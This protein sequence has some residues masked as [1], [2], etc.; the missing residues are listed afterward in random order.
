MKL[1]V[2]GKLFFVSLFLILGIGFAVGAFLE[3]ELREWVESGIESELRKHARSAREL[4]E[5]TR[6]AAIEDLDPLADRLGDATALR[7]T[8]ITNDGRILGDSGL[9]IEEIYSA[10]LHHRR[11][12]VV[13]ALQ[14]GIGVSRRHSVTLNT[15]ML[16]VAVPYGGR[17]GQSGVVRVAKPLTDVDRAI[18]ELRL[19]LVIGALLGVGLA[20]LM[21]GFASHLL[22]RTLRAL[23]AHA[24]SV[25]RMRPKAEHTK[26]EIAGIAGSLSTL[27]QELHEQ[28]S[29]LAQE[30]DRSAAILDS[31]DE[32]LFGLD[33]E[34]RVA[35]VNR[36]ALALLDLEEA[37]LERYM[38]NLIRVPALEQLINRA[39]GGESGT[40]EYQVAT[41]VARFFLA[42]AAPQRVTG[43][44]VVI[45]L[46]ITEVRRA[47]ELRRE[48]IAN[49]SHELRTPVSVIRANAETLL[50]G[51]ADDPKMRQKLI[52]ALQRHSERLSNIIADLLDL[53]RADA[54][55]DKLASRDVS[56]QATVQRVLLSLQD[57]IRAKRLQVADHTRPETQVRADPQALEQV[58]FNLLDNA[59][60]HIPPGAWIFLR[61]KSLDGTVRIEVEDSGP[62]IA[63]EHRQRLFE[64]FY[65]VDPGRSR[66]L[67]GTG[68]GL[69][70]VKD[71][72]VAMGGDVGMEP[73]YPKG[74]LFWLTLSAALD[75]P[76]DDGQKETALPVPDTMD[77]VSS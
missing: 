41:P 60:K 43:G 31:M 47:D 15:N 8:V 27:E 4:M 53:A 21:S 18:S 9:E 77:Q 59:V 22:T 72:C 16:Y 74:S 62:G 25:A 34:G 3:H 11:P 65:R 66:E 58:L 68:L 20:V 70:I 40:V 10:E 19:V 38:V 30:R 67:G 13:V 57:A 24:R 12:E 36:A 26:D 33:S 37:P 69:A 7:I 54:G 50:V 49:A 45:L 14:Q 44:C 5:L 76:P 48:F 2:R 55:R 23:L 56:V 61:D 6:S 1:G 39:L 75:R 63:E 71:L 28:M 73:A 51:A 64:R 52:G 42:K 17:E 29:N 32:A 35:L 46:D